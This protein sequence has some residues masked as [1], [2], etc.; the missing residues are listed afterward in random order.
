MLV[1]GFIT[2]TIC[3]G[4]GGCYFW[5]QYAIPCLPLF[6][7]VSTNAPRPCTFRFVGSCA[8]PW[9]IRILRVLPKLLP[10]VSSFARCRN[11]THGFNAV[12]AKSWTFWSCRFN[13]WL[14][15]I[16]LFFLSVAWSTIWIFAV[17]AIICLNRIIAFCVWHIQIRIAIIAS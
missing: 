5:R 9:S 7:F 11:D 10:A 12:F 1:F 2:F 6:R 3:T 13:Y 8:E 16:R 17:S 15:L 4:F 14:K